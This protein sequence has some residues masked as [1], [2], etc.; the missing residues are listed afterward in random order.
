MTPNLQTKT[1]MFK[2]TPRLILIAKR[3]VAAGEELLY[4]YGDRSKQSL[5]AHPW[6]AY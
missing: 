4:D 2:G 1:V 3:E 5:E 6:L